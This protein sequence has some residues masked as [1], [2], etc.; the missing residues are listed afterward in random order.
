L[1]PET[2][3]DVQLGGRQS[4]R[5]RKICLLLL[6]KSRSAKQKS[7]ET[8]QLRIRQFDDVNESTKEERFVEQ[9]KRSVRWVNKG[10]SKGLQFCEVD[11]RHNGEEI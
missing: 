9:S 4:A 5:Q 3:I 1:N 2:I 7:T 11:Q 10:V 8:H 6:P